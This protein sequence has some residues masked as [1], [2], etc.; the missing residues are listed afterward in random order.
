MVKKVMGLFIVVVGILVLL[1]NFDMIDF[2]SMA[3]AVFSL[4]I[5]LIGAAGLIEKR[6]FDF[7][8]SAFVL[9]GGLYFIANLGLIDED[10]IGL[11]VGPLLIVAIGLS[12]FFSLS[13]RIVDDKDKAN[14][15]AIFGG[16]EYK[17]QSNE[18]VSSEITTIFGGADID[19]RKIKFKDK[20]AYINVTTIFGGATIILP[21]DIK[22]TVKGL[23]LFGGAENKCVSNPEAKYEMII[24]YTAIFGGVEIK[25]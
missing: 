10:A 18:Y 17:N 12:L 13:K 25:N 7:I 16:V 15:V 21:D 19:Y 6:H 11:I 5:F 8:L 20:K 23:P 9:V 24:N 2:D 1:S 14:Y 4:G 3:N 22:V